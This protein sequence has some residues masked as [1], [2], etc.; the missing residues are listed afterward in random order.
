MVEELRRAAERL[1]ARIDQYKQVEVK[2]H[3]VLEISGGIGLEP[4]RFQVR[5]DSGCPEL[6]GMRQVIE[7][8]EPT[9]RI[10]NG[11]RWIRTRPHVERAPPRRSYVGKSWRTAESRHTR[12]SAGESA[13]SGASD[14]Y[15]KTSVQNQTGWRDQF[16]RADGTARERIYDARERVLQVADF[17]RGGLK[18]LIVGRYDGNER[19]V[20][21]GSPRQ[22]VVPPVTPPAWWGGN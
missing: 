4:Q 18:N 12:E 19:I 7:A 8:A 6:I 1:N 22:D 14:R 3:S 5:Q 20:F 15:W 11:E 17:D 13:T 10:V 16:S 21:E 2:A 9:P